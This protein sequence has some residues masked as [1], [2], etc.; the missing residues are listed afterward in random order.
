MQRGTGRP[1]G[2]GAMAAAVAVLP[3]GAEEF[4]GTVLAGETSA[5]GNSPLARSRGTRGGP[6]TGA[7]GSRPSRS[8]PGA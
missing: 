6:M 2:A 8:V 3:P 1:G 4:Y 7:P 5:R